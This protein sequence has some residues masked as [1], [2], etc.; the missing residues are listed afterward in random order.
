MQ[1]GRATPFC[2]KRV[3]DSF[4]GFSGFEACSS[5]AD[6]RQVQSIGFRV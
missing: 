5:G 6:V 1:K 3:T 2:D 4:V